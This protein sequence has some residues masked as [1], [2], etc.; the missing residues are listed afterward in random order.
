V[1]KPAVDSADAVG[2][3]WEPREKSQRRE[4]SERDAGWDCSSGISK[5]E[6]VRMP[7]EARR[8]IE[9]LAIC[10]DVVNGDMMGGLLLLILDVICAFDGGSDDFTGRPWSF[11]VNRLD[12]DSPIDA[13]SLSGKV[14]LSSTIAVHIDVP[15]LW[16][17]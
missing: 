4:G 14:L 13:L 2:K 12:M 11:V 16:L 15:F 3:M 7:P 10:R 6:R 8:A 5:R 9:L 1:A 17:L